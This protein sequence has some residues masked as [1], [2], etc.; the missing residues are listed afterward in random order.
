MRTAATLAADFNPRPSCE[1]R[2]KAKANITR[3][4]HFNPR[5]SCEGRLALYSLRAINRAFQSTSLLRGTTRRAGL[6]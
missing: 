5:P 2:L 4:Q 3:E 6:L 1:G